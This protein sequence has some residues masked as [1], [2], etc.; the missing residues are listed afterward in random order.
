MA[1]GTLAVLL[2]A[3]RLVTK[4]VGVTAFAHLS[5]VSWRKGALTGLALAPLSVFVILLIE[6]ARQT[7]VQVV[8]E[9]SAMAGVTML[10]EVFGPIII[11]RALVWAREAPERS[12]AA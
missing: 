8:E 11:Q 7:G 4:T 5:G 12:H 1:G 2:V 9:L 10:L 3:V 6:H